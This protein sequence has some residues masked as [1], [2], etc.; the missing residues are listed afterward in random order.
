MNDTG[1]KN[2]EIIYNGIDA[3]AKRWGLQPNGILMNQRTFNELRVQ[4]FRDI[5]IYRSPD[6]KE[7]EIRFII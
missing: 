7:N 4:S 1:V 5:P 3:F 2:E 6:C